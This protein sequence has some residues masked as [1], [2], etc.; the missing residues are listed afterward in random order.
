MLLYTINFL[1]MGIN[2][3]AGEKLGLQPIVE[4]YDKIKK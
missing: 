2:E 4:L 1:I 3:N